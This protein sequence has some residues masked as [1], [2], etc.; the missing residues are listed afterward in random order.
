M[1]LI[2]LLLTFSLSFSLPLTGFAEESASGEVS[3]KCNYPKQP[4]IPN[5]RTASEEDLV[6][7]QG[8]MKAYMA[9]GDEYIACITKVEEGWGDSA[10]DEQKAIIV[11]FNNKVVDD[12]QAVADLFNSAVRAYKGKK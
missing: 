3:G 1:K 6:A 10:S 11:L 2:T 5:G 9:E 4:E 7:A 8:N 12:M